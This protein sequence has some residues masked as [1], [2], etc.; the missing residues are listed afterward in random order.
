MKR[1]A[2]LS[3]FMAVAVFVAMSAFVAHA[4]DCPNKWNEPKEVT[5]KGAKKAD[6][7]GD[8][9][10]QS[11]TLAKDANCKADKC[12]KGKGKCRALRTATQT[13]TGDDEKGWTC[14]GNVRVGCFCLDPGEKG[15]IAPTPKSAPT[16]TE[17]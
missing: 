2:S 10:K 4:G 14:T 15:K 8:F 7:I 1:R 17:T 6:A 11:M 13:C 16:P 5:G 12:A 3:I 9:E